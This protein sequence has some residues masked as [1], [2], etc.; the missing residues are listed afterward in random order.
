MKKTAARR[1]HGSSS[2]GIAAMQS[3]VTI[4]PGARNDARR[5]M[6]EP[7]GND[8]TPET[9]DILNRADALLNRHRA[10]GKAASNTP[11]IPTPSRPV[12]DELDVSA[13][14]TLTDIVEMPA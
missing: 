10:A 7:G 5:A 6:S 12:G 13:I 2:T 8:D 11:A 14:P 4:F 3:R 1:A 9:D